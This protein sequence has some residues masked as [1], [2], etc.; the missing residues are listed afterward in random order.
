M[1]S[2]INQNVVMRRVPV[3]KI[4]VKVVGYRYKWTQNLIRTN[5]IHTPK[6]MNTL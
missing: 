3:H 5:S 6:L 2:I 4:Y 1:Q